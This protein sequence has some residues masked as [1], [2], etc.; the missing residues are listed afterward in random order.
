[1]IASILDK[2]ATEA[3]FGIGRCRPMASYRIILIGEYDDILPQ[4]EIA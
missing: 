3:W 4:T 1:M 2:T